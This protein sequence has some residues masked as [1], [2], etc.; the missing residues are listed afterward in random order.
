MSSIKEKF[1][2]TIK[3]LPYDIDEE[4]LRKD[5]KDILQDVVQKYVDMY[6]IE[7]LSENDKECVQSLIGKI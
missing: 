3:A 7:D 2:E 6:G 1:I 4:I 5:T